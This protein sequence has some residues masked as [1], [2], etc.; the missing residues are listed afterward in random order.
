M[1]GERYMEGN[2]IAILC[3]FIE[4]I[5]YSFRWVIK[6]HTETFSLRHLRYKTSYMP[7]SNNT[8]T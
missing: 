1:P 4:R 2:N 5:S 6:Q 7:N 3:D 8:Y